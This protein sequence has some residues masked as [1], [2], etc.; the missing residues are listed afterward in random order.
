VVA[1]VNASPE[2]QTFAD[3]AFAGA[4][5]LL[6]PI[7]QEASDPVVREASFDAAAGAFSVPGRTAA[8]FV[9][10]SDE[11]MPTATA[12]AT[13]TSQPTATAAATQVAQAATATTGPV[14]PP[15]ATATAVTEAT[16]GGPGLGILLGVG[17]L[18]VAG[19]G[20]A[21]VWARRG[22]RA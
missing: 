2:A 19:L 18:L 21:V 12:A 1:L 14:A 16:T 10:I 4:D 17:A 7:L 15:A 3:P 8:V 6:H 9:V 22:R 13:Q 20:A 5:L 11:P